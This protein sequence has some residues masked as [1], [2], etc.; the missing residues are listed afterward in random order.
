MP[1]PK[2]TVTKAWAGALVGALGVGG[3]QAPSVASIEEAV[4][5]LIQALAGAMVGYVVTWL[6]PRNRDKH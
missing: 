4:T 2:Q 1:E 3:P 6:A 5:I